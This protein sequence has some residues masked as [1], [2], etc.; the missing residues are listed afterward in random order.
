MQD[1]PEEWLLEYWR[2]D[3][4]YYSAVII[5]LVLGTYFARAGFTS[6]VRHAS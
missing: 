1:S 5:V 3:V 6:L 2:R 4:A